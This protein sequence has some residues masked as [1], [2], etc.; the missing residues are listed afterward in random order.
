VRV[1]LATGDLGEGH[2]SAARA[3]A[4]AF[5]AAYPGGETRTVETM[6]LMG[7]TLRSGTR[8]SYVLGVGPFGW[9]Y[10]VFFDAVWRVPGPRGHG[11]PG[12]P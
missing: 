12:P 2:N 1:L 3:L 11:T 10:Q 6:G 9:C 4:E 8:W 7:A 5:Q